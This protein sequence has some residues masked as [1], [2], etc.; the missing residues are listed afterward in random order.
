MNGVEEAARVGGNFNRNANFKDRV[1][2]ILN[3]MLG[4]KGL[5]GDLKG[6]LISP[7]K[8]SQKKLKS[9]GRVPY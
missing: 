2:A 4:R 5:K 9:V 8:L 6:D 1:L 7:T 3:S